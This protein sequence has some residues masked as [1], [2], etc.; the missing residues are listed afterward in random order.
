[1]AEFR[2]LSEI[3]LSPYDRARLL[4][5]RL[6]EL[7]PEAVD[8]D[9]CCPICLLTFR[10]FFEEGSGSGN[11]NKEGGYEQS[12]NERGVT[13]LVGCGHVFCRKDLNEWILGLHGTCPI[14]RHRF[15]DIKPPS[16]SD[17]ESSDGGEWLPNSNSDDPDF[18]DEEDVFMDETDEFGDVEPDVDLRDGTGIGDMDWQTD[19]TDWDEDGGLGTDEDWGLTDWD[20]SMSSESGFASAEESTAEDTPGIHD[21]TDAETSDSSVQGGAK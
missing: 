17:D 14:C 12:D 21:G 1:M 16:E 5:S 11:E 13:K 10:T 15:L 4:V 19:G 7:K 6:P 2:P 18:E 20:S 3:C 9:E 8:L